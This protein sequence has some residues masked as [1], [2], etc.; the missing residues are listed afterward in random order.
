MIYL[1]AQ[2]GTITGGLLLIIVFAFALYSYSIYC[3]NLLRINQI[4][5]GLNLSK[6]NQLLQVIEFAIA[7]Y[8]YK[9]VSG[10]S[11]IVELNVSNGV[12]FHFNLAPSSFQ[13]SIN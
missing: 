2:T 11:F 4:D 9:Y 1:V 7:G 12:N 5:K 10:G 13:L 6:I 8:A 3:G